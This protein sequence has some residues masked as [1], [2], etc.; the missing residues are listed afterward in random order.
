MTNSA[1]EE[2]LHVL[3]ELVELAPDVR[4]GQLVVNLSYLARGP[5]NDSI[6]EVADEELLDAARKQLNEWRSRQQAVEA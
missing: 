6:W 3:A 4:L 1:R 5:S 2:I